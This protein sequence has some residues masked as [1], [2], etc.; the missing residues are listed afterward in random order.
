[1]KKL[2]T[3]FVIA[4][5]AA[6]A[7][8]QNPGDKVDILGR[9]GYCWGADKGE[10]F[11]YE[12]GV[13]TFNSISWAGLAA[14]IGGEDWSGYS[15]LV[16]EY[17]EPTTVATQIQIQTTAGDFTSWGSTGVTSV[18]LSFEDKDVTG[19]N[20]L[21]LQASDQA[22]IVI[23]A[24]Y[25]VVAEKKD[26][27]T[28]DDYTELIT[29][30]NCEGDD[31]TNFVS[32][33]YV[34]AD[35]SWGPSRLVV[36][37]TNEN[38]K[39]IEVISRDD[40]GN[41]VD[42]EGKPKAIDDYDTQFFITTSEKL[43]P[44]DKY[45]ITFKVRAEKAANAQTQAHD[46]PG[47]YNHWVGIGDVAFTDGWV[48]IER[49]GTI[50]EDQVPAGK[51]MHTIA[52]NLALL[53]EANKYYFDDI[54]LKVLKQEEQTY[55]D[56]TD[57]I[58]N[59]NCEGTETTNYIS[60]EY[61]TGEEVWG[62]SRLVA[63]PIDASNKCIEVVSRDIPEGQE[64]VVDW[65]TQFFI[66]VADKLLPGD[67]YVISFRV[68]A[69][70]AASAQTQ[71]HN[72][73]GE[74]NHYYI[75][76][77]IPF[78]TQW[79]DIKKTGTITEDQVYKAGNDRDETNEMHTIAFNLGVLKEANKYYFD[80]IKFLVKKAPVQNLIG[81]VNGDGFVNITDVSI[82]VDYVLNGNTEFIIL[83]NADMNNDGDVN[84]T[85]ISA[86]VNLVLGQE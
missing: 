63:D 45:H 32:K 36:D 65:D 15:K 17:A 10:S 33:E 54:S 49:N 23:T 76:G 52:F 5:I 12:N 16:F 50:S 6:T 20:Q 79:V 47:N 25:L 19:V 44:G 62:P 38:N 85:D 35:Q 39:C 61:F 51:E 8:A 72:Q 57:L 22:T 48:E 3:L 66:T 28:Y 60:K 67:E 68:R 13:I 30:G 82:T 81:D 86:L 1:M 73:P 71:T 84:I 46:A 27:V 21:A 29:N 7:Y 41:L 42:N 14:W 26:P 70:K 78:T 43:E 18:E 59:G 77:D 74:Y 31:V 34:T 11:T 58:T 37:P 56:F 53:K 75:L 83:E 55:D 2:L 9:F 80:D 64:S 40:P 69:D 24:A 4:V